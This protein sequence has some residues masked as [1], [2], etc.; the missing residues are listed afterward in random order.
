[1]ACFHTAPRVPLPPSIAVVWLAAMLCGMPFMAMAAG[2]T[3]RSPANKLLDATPGHMVTTSAV[4]SSDVGGECIDNLDLPK[5]CGRVA[6]MDLPFNLASGG[7]IVRLIAIHVPSSMPGGEYPV[8]YSVRSRKIP[9]AADSMEFV[10]KV[11]AVDHLELVVDPNP[12]PVLAGDTY[13]V[14]LH[15]ANRGNAAIAAQIKAKSSLNFNVALESQAFSLAAGATRDLTALVRTPKDFNRHTSHAVTFDVVASSPSGKALSAS[16]AS[17]ADIIPLVSGDKQKTFHTLPVQTRIIGLAQSHG[18]SQMQAEL[19]GEGTLDENGKHM[20]TFLFRGPDLQNTNLF[21]ERD[22]YGM[23][24][25]GEHLDVDIGDRIYSLTPLLEKGS[26][27]RGAGMGWH[28]DGMAA[29]VFTMSSRFRQ[30]NTEETGAFLRQDL[31]QDLSLQA[32]Y[33][34][35]S[36]DDPAA[37]WR[38]PQDLVSLEARYHAGKALDLRLEGGLSEASSGRQ[39]N[40]WRLDARGTLPGNLTYVVEHA[41][42]GPNFDGYYSGNDLTYVSLGKDFT[43]QFRA[44]LSYNRYQGNP[45]LNDIL[46]SVVNSENSWNVGVIYSLTKD[47]DTELSFDYNHIQREDILLPA[48]YKFTEDSVRFGIGQ[49]IGKLNARLFVDTGR[50]DNLIS[51]QAGSFVRYGG[52]LNWRPTNSQTWSAFASYGPSPFTGAMDQNLS[53]GASGR[54]QVT[55]NTSATVS[56]TRNQ[57]DGLTGTQQDQAMVTL[58]H[59]FENKS[60]IALVGR[61]A[62]GILTGVAAANS[63][64]MDEKALFV[65]YTIPFSVNVSRNTS[66]GSLEGRLVDV[67][68]GGGRNG[69]ARAVIQIDQQFAATDDTGHFSFPL[70]KPGFHQLLILPDSLGPRMAFASPLPMQVNVDSAKTAWVDLQ[71]TAASSLTVTVERKVFADG[72]NLTTSGALKSDGGQEG[73]VVEIQN[74]RDT[75][76]AETDRLG[77]ATFERLLPGAWRVRLSAPN[78]P[79]LNQLDLTDTKLT[80]HPGKAHTLLARVIPEKRTLKMLDKGYIQ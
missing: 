5:G 48:A 66:T 30:H 29:G 22:E 73:V 45:A 10:L 19:S 21:G 38:L 50:L 68:P 63:Q 1:M 44:H 47:R 61:W 13:V 54:W 11:A 76:R 27:G 49:N 70:L 74:D 18:S 9:S 7:Q 41:H 64:A 2:L 40:A 37:S 23:S 62:H 46:S 80:L 72:N 3:V 12:N 26:L 59:Q 17:V 39:D 43:N 28:Q 34:H 6:P 60:S 8:R 69:V 15:L 20:I 52:I 71:A 67:T 75:W 57:F 78:L 25:R 33:L 14:R 31:M 56:Y 51:A 4:V 55:S 58:R 35:K 16:Q 42:A 65:T 77:H 53:A 36:G 79:S 32:S 24:Y